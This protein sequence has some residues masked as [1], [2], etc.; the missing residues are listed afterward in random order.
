[1]KTKIIIEKS[2]HLFLGS[3]ATRF[4]VSAREV[5]GKSLSI[6]RTSIQNKNKKLC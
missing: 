5:T 3:R 1:M 4:V 2:A 6:Y